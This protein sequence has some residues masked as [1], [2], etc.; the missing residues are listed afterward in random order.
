[1]KRTEAAATAEVR[2]FHRKV[3]HV[4]NMANTLPDLSKLAD[5]YLQSDLPLDVLL[6]PPTRTFSRAKPVDIV[7]DS[8][9]MQYEF[10][11]IQSRE[12][13]HERPRRVNEAHEM[14]YAD[15]R[16][17]SR[18]QIRIIFAKRAKKPHRP[19]RVA[20]QDDFDIVP[21]FRF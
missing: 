19:K 2:R 6:N 15:H 8:Y 5:P 11:A 14:V 16:V 3:F 4:K 1:M 9:V 18:R 12:I 20:P 13:Q 17:P 7:S 10:P 21:L